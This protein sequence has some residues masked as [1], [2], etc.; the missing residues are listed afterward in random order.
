MGA[1]R[2]LVAAGVVI[3][4]LVALLLWRSRPDD[5]PAPT[6]IETH[7]QVALPTAPPPSLPAVAQTATPPQL[8]PQPV[9]LPESAHPP[10][11]DGK[12]SEP[13]PPQ[14]PFTP[15][16]QIAKREADLALLDDTKAR[17]EEQLTAARDA[18]D[19]ATAHD[20]EIRIARLTDVRK[21]RG[22]E[23]DKLRAGSA[24]P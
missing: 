2:A 10:P 11:L 12:H 19:T 13:A 20:L 16:E 21:K 3:A 4:V 6:I 24:Q 9:P 23:L 14:K 15:E 1:R 8:Q 22:E 18:H 17:L 5:R 7:D